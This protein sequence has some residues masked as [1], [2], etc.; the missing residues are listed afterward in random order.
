MCTNMIKNIKNIHKEQNKTFL[1]KIIEHNGKA[2]LKKISFKKKVSIDN[3][4]EPGNLYYIKSG[5]IMRSF[6]DSDGHTKAVGLLS[7]DEILGFATLFGEVPIQWTTTVLQDTEILVIT[8]KLL[9]DNYKESLT[10]LGLN[11]QYYISISYL[12]WQSAFSVGFERINFTLI[13]LACCLGERVKENSF[14]MP[15]YISHDL[16]ASFSSVTRSYVTRHLSKLMK[17]Q[18]ISIKN[19]KICIIDMNKLVLKTPNYYS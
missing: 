16:I 5:V 13:N 7:K 3:L 17:E 4:L 14:R 15:N 12:Y 18:I 1:N 6:S 10:L 2:C 19:N 11:F 9:L 8:N